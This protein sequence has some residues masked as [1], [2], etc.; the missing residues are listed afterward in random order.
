MSDVSRDARNLLEQTIDER[1]TELLRTIQSLQAQVE[2]L[3][4][5]ETE[6]LREIAQLKVEAGLPKPY[7][8]SQ[9]P[10]TTGTIIGNSP[11][12]KEILHLV[13]QVAC[14]PSAV[15]IIGETGTGK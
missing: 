10:R 11:A 4:R 2:E 15:L 3:K 5:G 7:P 1:T 13:H 12:I 9:A 14:T 6:L 8:E